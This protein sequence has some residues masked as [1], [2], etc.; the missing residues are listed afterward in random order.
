MVLLDNGNVG[1][2]TTNPTSTLDINRSPSRTGSHSS[3]LGLY[4]TNGSNNI[5]EFRESDGTQGIGI[6]ANRIYASGS[7]TNQN[8]SIIPRGT[9]NVGIG[10][11][12]PTGVL[13]V[14][15]TTADYTNSLVVRTPWASVVLDNT[16]TSGGRKWSILSGG[17][18]AGIG[19]GNL[20]IFDIIAGAYRFSINSSGDAKCH[21][22][23]EVAGELTVTKGDDS[24]TLYGP[25]A[26]WSTYLVVGSGTNRVASTIAQVICTNGNLHLDAA[27]SKDIY[28]G[29]YPN[30][31]GLP[32][33][34]LF[35]G[36]TQINNKFSVGKANT[37]ASRTLMT[38]SDGEVGT[39]GGGW[40]GPVTA[41][42]DSANGTLYSGVS[43]P[44][45]GTSPGLF[46]G[47]NA[48]VSAGYITCLEPSVAWKDLYIYAN[49]TSVYNTGSLVAFTTSGGWINVSDERE[50]EDI[51]E[52]KTDKSLQ[53][54][55]ALKPKHYKRKFYDSRTPVPDE[56][57]QR[58]HVGFIAQ[59]VQKS[60]PHCIS[61]WSNK[62][63]IKKRDE[64][65]VEI[66]VAQSTDPKVEEED[67]QVKISIEEEE[68]DG[69]RF[70]LSYNDYVVH[71]VGA[72]QEQQ[73][74]INEQQRMINEQQRM[75]NEQTKQLE[76]FSQR[77]Q[78]LEDHARKLE[79][80]MIEYRDQTDRRMTQLAELVK[81]LLE[82]KNLPKL[83][84]QKSVKP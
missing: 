26:S 64:A 73:R 68:D 42:P 72:V 82:E 21:K 5:A 79:M 14:Y 56:E 60:N 49:S 81:G 50:K 15:S 25:N 71:L 67:V 80:D 54:V 55:L 40:F 74:M 30:S 1:I 62:E 10:T 66:N 47:Y 22:S 36:V 84:R 11:T 33:K 57:K 59:E 48:A 29:F 43:A 34:H 13:D 18:G 28:Y 65:K 58:R 51:H 7:N 44:T 20:G 70:G 6:G 52:L 41:W 23:L 27:T 31:A 32:N 77:N 39:S 83:S 12:N 2:G 3:G 9:G 78:I 76:V 24:I 69:G 38:V 8:I 35:Y 63:S 46:V 61:T 53:R 17:T 19:V 45:T 37:S 75:I 4:V 16:Q